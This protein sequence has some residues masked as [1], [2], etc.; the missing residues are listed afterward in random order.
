LLVAGVCGDGTLNTGEACDNG[1]NIGTLGCSATCTVDPNWNCDNLDPSI[2][3][4][5]GNGILETF[6]E[7]CDDGNNAPGDGCSAAC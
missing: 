2:C 1:V 3:Y 7:T 5:C 4:L 6:A